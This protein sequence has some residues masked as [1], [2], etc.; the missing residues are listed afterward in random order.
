MISSSSLTDKQ[1]QRFRSLAL[2]TVIVVYLLILAGGIVRSTGSG[3]G[4]PDWPTCFGRWVPPTEVS[5]LPLNYQEIYGVKLKGEVEFNATKTWIEYVNRLLG[6]IAGFCVF[7][8]LLASSSYLRKDKIIF[9]GSLTAF[10]LIGINGWLGSRVVATELAQYMITLHL[11]LAIAVVFALLFV[12]VRS[13]AS[14]LY[15]DLTVH[16]TKTLCWLLVVVMLLTL[17]QIVFG[18]QVRE[19]LDAVVK[20]LGYERRADWIDNLNWSFYIHRSFSLIV[21]AFHVAVVYQLRRFSNVGWLLSLTKALI[22]VVVA[23]ICTGVV[24]AYFNVPAVAQPIHL[25]LAVLLIGL[26]FV[27]W[28]SLNPT[29]P[30]PE[31][32]GQKSELVEV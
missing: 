18:A 16:N 30:L 23:E 9:W 5:Q 11:L 8:T 19:A 27:A 14:H 12:V 20:R 24:M 4:C 25:V 32:L 29:I 31:G 3:M 2:L 15:A 28:L 6:V 10:L 1:E 17:I 21:L 26:Q 7:G 13:N 22:T